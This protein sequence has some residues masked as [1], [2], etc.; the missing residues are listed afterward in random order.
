MVLVKVNLDKNINITQGAMPMNDLLLTLNNH[1]ILQTIA[2]LM[3]GFAQKCTVHTHLERTKRMNIKSF[4]AQM[5]DAMNALLRHHLTLEIV[6][7]LGHP[8]GTRKNTYAIIAKATTMVLENVPISRVQYAMAMVTCYG[9]A[10][11]ESRAM[12]RWSRMRFSLRPR[13]RA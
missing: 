3:S 6:E 4:I 12:G 1:M 13:R 5:V 2:T 11:T 10:Q 8:Y 7:T 9:S